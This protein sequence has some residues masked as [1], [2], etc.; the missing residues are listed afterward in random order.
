MN[1]ANVANVPGATS[2]PSKPASLQT[3]PQVAPEPLPA[4]PAWPHKKNPRRVH[5]CVFKIFVGA[6]KASGPP[7]L[8]T[9]TR[10]LQTCTFEGPGASNTTKIAREDPQRETKR[11]IMGAGEEKI[12]GD[13]HFGALPFEAPSLQ[14]PT[15]FRVGAPPFK[16]HRLAKI[17]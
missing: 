6:S 11:T 15:F 3:I 14:G 10:E 5:R 17:G 9:T 13:P 2:A 1:S 7:G 16:A 8:H 4:R 12:L